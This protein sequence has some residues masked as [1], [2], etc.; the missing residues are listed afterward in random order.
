MISLPK[1]TASMIEEFAYTDLM[2]RS[3]NGQLAAGPWGWSQ[4]AVDFACMLNGQAEQSQNEPVP[5]RNM[6]EAIEALKQ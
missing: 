4:I 1:I 6:D 3:Y 2:Q 5:V